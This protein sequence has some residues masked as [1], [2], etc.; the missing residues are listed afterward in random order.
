[1]KIDN[2]VSLLTQILEYYLHESRDFNGLPSSQMKNYD[3]EEIIKLITDDK[4]EIISEND[5]N[6]PHIKGFDFKI[7]LNTQCTYINENKHFV[8]YPTKNYLKSLP[9]TEERPFT[10]M[11]CLGEHQLQFIYFELEILSTYYENPMYHIWDVGY[12]GKISISD[13]YYDDNNDEALHSELIENYS[14]AY[15]KGKGNKERYVGLLLC[16]LMKLNKKGQFKFYPYLLDNQEEY[17]TH[18]NSIKNLIL[19]EFADNVWIYD[20]LLEEMQ[21]INQMC[22]KIGLSPLFKNPLTK[23]DRLNQNLNYHNIVI[24]TWKNYYNFVLDLDKIIIQSISSSTFTK[25]VMGFLSVSVPEKDK[26]N[27]KTLNLFEEWIGLNMKFPDG[28]ELFKVDCINSLRKIRKERQTP[29]HKLEENAYDID[30]FSK[31][32][33]LIIDAYSRTYNP[34]NII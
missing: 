21:I 14:L 26:T 24:P 12:R 13:R 34:L 3:K 33:E 16:D 15:K 17:Y 23:D 25:P 18:E 4:I 6:N 11:L 9:V 7:P 10:K 28:G 1:M 29:A 20:A 19:G 27:P 5:A 30:L 32:N 22:D 2:Q 31:Q 8:A